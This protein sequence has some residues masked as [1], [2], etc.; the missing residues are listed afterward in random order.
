MSFW[1]SPHTWLGFLIVLAIIGSAILF[2]WVY[3]RNQQ[4]NLLVWAF[5]AALLTAFVLLL[6]HGMTGRLAGILIDERNKMS[7]SRLQL[8]IWTILILSA[9]LTSAEWNV[10]KAFPTPLNIVIP[11]TVWF[12]L[13]ISATSFV[14]QP[15]ILNTKTTS[16]ADPTQMNNNMDI[17]ARQRGVALTAPDVAMVQPP[18]TNPVAASPQFIPPS[19]LPSTST[20]IVPTIDP[21]AGNQAAPAANPGLPAI[22]ATPL[23]ATSSP[24]GATLSDKLDQLNIVPKGQLVTY[25]NPTD[26]RFADM[27][28]GEETGNMA[29]L[30][31]SKIQ[32]FYFTIVVAVAYAAALS[33]IMIGNPT[34][35]MISAFPDLSQG[36]VVLLGISH[37]GYLGYKAV[38]HSSLTPTLR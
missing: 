27:F 29:Q 10:L 36:M 25:S 35:S 7:L 26:A 21:L 5:N 9:F 2:A 32:M 18:L 8:I 12:L 13:G 38:P 17:L 3:T 37:A 24:S 4:D 28:K 11:D 15:L 16:P 30:D 1:R 23:P 6:G 14:A 19:W 34:G 33:A 22:V 31:L 20:P